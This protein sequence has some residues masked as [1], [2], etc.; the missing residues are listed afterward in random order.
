MYILHLSMYIPFRVSVQDPHSFC[1]ILYNEASNLE[2]LA[3]SHVIPALAGR[4][5][6]FLDVFVRALHVGVYTGAPDCWKLSCG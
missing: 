1:R 3:G 4:T 2:T 6:R 5:I